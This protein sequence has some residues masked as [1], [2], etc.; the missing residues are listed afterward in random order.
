MFYVILFI[1]SIAIN[2]A[3]AF[4]WASIGLV[5]VGLFFVT[6]AALSLVGMFYSVKGFTTPT[7][8]L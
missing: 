2:L 8:R 4:A 5:G 3:C 1:S 6:A 7:N